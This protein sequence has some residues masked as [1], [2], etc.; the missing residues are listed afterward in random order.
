[1]PIIALTDNE[2]IHMRILVADT[3][4]L[5]LKAAGNFLASLP[6][7]EAVL[8]ASAA[9]A[10]R[11]A[12]ARH[13]DLVLLD[14][15]LRHANGINVT[16]QLK[17]LLPPPLLVLLVAEDAASY[18]NACLK[19]GA[20]GCASKADLGME[21]PPLLSGLIRWTQAEAREH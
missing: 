3:N 1:V 18:R 10:L 4:L 16:R 11:L 13:F 20:D 6:A 7:C 19:A 2:S 8:A 21:L 17:L 15:G 5:F 14:Y 9:D 12:P